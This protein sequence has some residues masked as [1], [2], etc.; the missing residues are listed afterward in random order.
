MASRCWLWMGSCVL[1]GLLMASGLV[2]CAG[3]G[4]VPTATPTKTS[5]A[6]RT[7][8]R[9]SS[10]TV[11]TT[12]TETPTATATNTTAPS[13]T[14]TSTVTKT[15]SPSPS[16]TLSASVTSTPTE[17]ATATPSDTA[18]G[19]PTATTTPTITSSPTPTGPVIT[20]LAGTGLAGLN[21]DGLKPVNTNLYL[22]QDVTW[23]PDGL[24]YIVDW[25]NHR[26]RRIN[27]DVV[28]TVCGSGELGDAQD[29]PGLEVNFNHPT[30]V[31][32]DRRGNM[33]IA[34]WH[35]SVVK[36]FDFSTG[37]VHNVAGTGARAFSGDEGPAGKAAFNLPS[38]VVVD[39]AGRIFVSDQANY[40][41]RMIDNVDT[42]D[43]NGTIHPFAGNGTPGFAGDNQPAS[44]AE[45]NSP[46]GQAAAPAGR[47]TIDAQNRIYVADTGNHRI[48]LI[49]SDGTIRTIAGTGTPGYNGDNQLATDAQLNTPS[50]V[51]VTPDGSVYIA[52]T[53]N[54]RIRKV[55]PGG[56][57]TTIAGSGAGGFSGDGGLATEAKLDRPYGLDVGPDGTV[58]IA[59]THNHRIRRVTATLPPD[60]D[61]NGGGDNTKVTIIPCSSDVGSICTYV[62]T[63]EEGFNGDGLDRLQSA[64]YWPFDIEF[65]PQGRRV[66]LDW[67]NHKV[68]EILADDTLTT[69]MGSDFVGDGPPDLSDNTDPGAIPTT[70]NLNHP[71]EVREFPNGDILVHA[72]H[73][74]K[75]RELV[76][77]TNRVKVLV[78]AGA[79]FAGDTMPAKKALLNQPPHGTFD[80]NG[81]YFLIDQRNQRIRVIY[82]FA[83]QRG[84]G[85]INTVVGTGTAGFNGDGPAL[86]TQLN[87]PAGPNPEPSGGIVWAGNNSLYFSDTKNNRIRRVD[88]QS[89]DF[90]TATV[91]TIAGTGSAAFGGDDGPALSAQLNQ[92]EDLALGPD[93][94]LYFADTNNNR[95]RMIY[96]SANTIH[97]VAG[98][99]DPSYGGDGGPALAAQ[100]WR[101]FGVAFDPYGDLYISD[102]FNGRIRRVN[103]G[104]EP[105]PVFPA[106]YRASFTEVR[107]CR[108]S[109]AHGGV[110][111][112]VWANA[113]G[114]QP[115]VDLANP[116]PQDTVVVKEEFNG[117]DCN[118]DSTL[119]Q[120]RAMRKEAP[121]FDP[122]DGD[123]HWQRVSPQRVV[124]FD[125]K[126]TCISC[127][128]A[129]DCLVRDHMCTVDTNATPNATPTVTGTPPTAVPTVTGTPPT[130]TPP[131]TGGL[132]TVTPTQSAW[133]VRPVQFVLQ[134]LSG[135]L[136]SIAGTSAND[137]YT[138]GADP[139]DGMGPLVLHYSGGFWRRLDSGASSN[140]W[141]ISVTPIDG[142]F[143]MAGEHGLVLRYDPSTGIFEQLQTPGT[144]T[145]YGIWGTDAQHIWAVGG[146]PA[147]PST[148]GVVWE[149]NGT[150]W[151]VDSFI[152]NLV[153]T[154][155]PTLFK[156]WGRSSSD[157]WVA[158]S[159]GLIFHFDG[160]HWLQENVDIGGGDPQDLPFFTV[161]GNASE[162][163]A[164]GGL[165]NGVIYELI[166][167]TFLDRATPGIQQMNGIFLRPDGSGVSVGNGGSVALRS[168]NGWQ[169]QQPGLN[170]PYDF[171]ATWVDPDGGVWAVGGDLSVNLDHGILAYGGPAAIGAMILS[172][173]QCAPGSSGGPMTVSY[174]NDVVPLFNQTGCMNISCHGG[175]FPTSGYDL[176]AYFS[177]F[178]PGL[179]AASLQACDIVP[180]S[181]DTSYLIKK[182]GPNPPMGVQMPDGRTPLTTNQI[183]LLRT[184]ILEGAQ[185]D[186]PPAPTATPTVPAPQMTP[187]LTACNNAGVICT[188]AGT[189]QAQ[190]DGDGR[191]ALQ[192]SFYYP[193]EI[194]FDADDRP[195]ILDFNNLRVRGIK[196]DG[197]IET[198]MGKNF[199][200]APVNGALASD[201]PLHHASDIEFD[202]GG[203]LYVAG[204]HVAYVFRVG[205][206]DRVQI[207]AGNGDI[208]N[209][210]DGMPAVSAELTTPFGVAPTNDGGFYITDVDA[211][212]IRYVD[213]SGTITT[214]AGS[215]MRGY[216]GDKGP[217]L[218]AKLANPTR[219]RV[220]A[221]GNLYFCDTNNNVVRRVDKTGTITTVAGTGTAG[222]SGD[223]KAATAAE[224]KTP[225]DLRVAP[226][227]DLYIADTGN[228][229][230]RRVDH[231]GIVTTV[232]GTG[233]AGFAG[234]GGDARNC[235]LSRPSG[236][237]FDKDGSLWVSDT[238]NERVRRVAGLLSL[239]P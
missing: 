13:N 178:G 15:L 203:Q 72:W 69:I 177:S 149:F 137:V 26:I 236:L 226:N 136:L 23:G 212:V 73:N 207:V 235:R 115:Y 17:T 231:S 119:V 2:A 75:L 74:H 135:A 78:G 64:L 125:T 224:F 206:D 120:W 103:R 152:G 37:I 11:T 157:V 191:P 144:E 165:V 227:G 221:S 38:S 84:D 8:T 40:R 183:D 59:D 202:N 190:F 63:G 88:F 85:I 99:G 232:V 237:N 57:I 167:G 139:H 35:N 56:I 96:L 7:A 134:G 6:T 126:D 170:T 42:L 164:S 53:F 79:G 32:F 210:G 218:S 39:T 138:V 90:L 108:F 175:T 150:N 186:A 10:P 213:P 193:F 100:L 173:Q 147:K 216:D 156:V 129:P 145:I 122:V 18:T 25:N 97:T 94:N 182:L 106:N 198:I 48:R 153:P 176:H 181:P 209:T 1:A 188:V 195:L 31:F 81:D 58:Y 98:T 29:G 71:T 112:R 234:D 169:L 133:P 14:Q 83:T 43:L 239:Y 163:V 171:H 196:A 148:G 223:T 61:P 76:K 158:G 33:L 160:I 82:N 102:T 185:N 194:A 220:D 229:V 121:G 62:G 92:P 233:L 168:P 166:N 50:D 101:P 67:N 24:L 159:L 214:V 93:G 225:Y 91:T 128:A 86:Q 192:T 49:D 197:T 189:G 184:W 155:L 20:T 162:V 47:I 199:E 215:G 55:S 89:A 95:V 118:D 123:W 113:I 12:S 34:A 142:A 51:A 41:I 117:P 124:V 211:G 70:V 219:V 104:G 161:H 222:Y 201:T 105:Q 200:G 107:G 146:D 60:Y 154:G 65:T 28:E 151:T 114:A 80:P 5:T 116:L 44:M 111:V 27:N 46:S 179:E 77:Q 21:G 87:F 109:A 3:D 187:T 228:S 22:P 19:T 9:T 217:A 110:N 66:V 45:L 30:N 208:G 68:R 140:L 172:A 238:F 52:D 16:S 131:P 4:T 230:I 174:T 180:G 130:A 132:P 127:H 54:N 141:W 36:M 205:T 204:D 143:Y